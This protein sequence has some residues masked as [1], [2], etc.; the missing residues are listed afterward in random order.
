[1]GRRRYSKRELLALIQIE[2]EYGAIT[3]QQP[4]LLE[5]LFLELSGVYRKS[6][7]LYMAMWRIKA[8]KYDHILY[9]DGPDLFSPDSTT[10]PVE[11]PKA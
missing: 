1:M 8:G 6:G 7:T 2:A 11:Q 4:M 5:Q 10:Q 9:D 3:Y